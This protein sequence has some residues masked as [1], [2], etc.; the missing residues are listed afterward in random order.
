MMLEKCLANAYGSYAILHRGFV[1]F[2]LTDL[3]GAM[4]EVKDE[5]TASDWWDT[6]YSWFQR[7]FA[8]FAENDYQ[9]KS[10][11]PLKEGYSFAIIDL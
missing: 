5:G 7:S 11:N 6:L 9:K 4:T 10:D 8:M 1:N 2:C 3:T